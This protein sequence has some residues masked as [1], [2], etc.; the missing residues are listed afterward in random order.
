MLC[1]ASLFGQHRYR[2]GLLPQVN[3]NVKVADAWKLNTKL[4]S[5]QI[6]SRGA[7]GQASES[8]YEYERTDL[9]TVLAYKSA[10][11][12]S[13]AAGYMLR[14]AGQGFIHRTIQ[15]Y[16]WVRPYHGFRLGHRLSSDQTFE[17]GEAVQFRARY[18]IALDRALNGE[19]VDS[20]ESY[21]KVTNEWLH[22]LQDQD[23]DLEMRLVPTWGYA[24]TDNNK[25]EI[26]L[27]YRL[28]L[29][30]ETVRSNF[31]LQVA[32]YVKIR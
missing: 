21:L 18:R 23:Y 8:S 15:Q 3:L 9:A 14:V 20:K 10:A 7:F 12:A 19:T 16:S 2:M 32:W 13:F 28:D 27:D 29:L 30:R 17:Y 26:G 5:R 31:W 22:I 1:C 11:G 25:V 6:L 4:E 24:F